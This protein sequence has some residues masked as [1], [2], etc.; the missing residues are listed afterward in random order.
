MRLPSEKEVLILVILVA[1]ILNAYTFYIAYPET[2]KPEFTN[3]ARDFSAYYLAEWRLFHNPSEI[4]NPEALP[5]DYQILPRAQPFK[6]APSFLLLFLPVVTLNYQNALNAFDVLQLAL[7]PILAFFV[8]KLV[9]EK[10]LILGSMV[11]VV[12]LVSPL[13]SLQIEIEPNNGLS[14]HLIT[15]SAQ[16]LSPNYFMGYTVANAHVLQTVLL[17]GA[18]YFA[19]SKKPWLSALLLTL[20]SFDPRCA[21]LAL[22]LLLWYNRAAVLKFVA[23]ATMFLAGSNLPFFFYYGVGFT[24]LTN[25]T[26]A[27]IFSQ[28]YQYDWIPLYSIAALTI[29]EAITVIQSRKINPT[30]I[31]H[32]K[33]KKFGKIEN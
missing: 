17:V 16:S 32:V 3:L 26:R 10:N 22:P 15:L 4:Y 28:L 30:F 21:I 12:I 2:F 6:Y 20:G 13:P 33:D 25:G 31:S 23:G 7:I 24:F 11:A 8:Y 5:G 9:K 1:V 14:Y 19:F 27:Y 29:A 18:I